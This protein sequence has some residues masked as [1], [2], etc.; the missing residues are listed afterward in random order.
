MKIGEL[1]YS[2]R[3]MEIGHLLLGVILDTKLTTAGRGGL[4]MYRI[5]WV[6]SVEPAWYYE[7]EVER[8]D[9]TG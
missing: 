9:A 3:M 2:G 7:S 1:V 5:F 4:Q 8:I 6:D